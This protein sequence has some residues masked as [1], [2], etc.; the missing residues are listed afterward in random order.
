MIKTI[1]PMNTEDEHKLPFIVKGIGVQNNQEP[2]SRPNGF[3]HFHWAHCDTGEG[4][5]ILGGNEY[6]IIPGTGFFFKPGLPHQYYTVKEPWQ[7]YWLI[8]DGPALPK[9]LSYMDLPEWGVMNILDMDAINNGLQNIYECLSSELPDKILE[10]SSLLY[11]FL[12][13]LKNSTLW[14][15]GDQNEKSLQLL[16]VISYMENNYNKYSSVEDMANIIGV[17]PYHFCRLFKQAFHLSPFKYLTRLR[18]QKA[19]ELLVSSSNMT[20]KEIAKTTGYNDSSYF[21][22]VFK[23]HEKLTPLE[24]RKMHGI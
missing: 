24:F 8:F 23:E 3:P 4:K 5:L 17:S 16:P 20:V 11:K 19:K 18:I 1:F 15:G 10:A 13:I 7:I 6:R 14:S 21:C 22:S 12:V 9:L 2:I